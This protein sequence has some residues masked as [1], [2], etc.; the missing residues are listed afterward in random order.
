M[1]LLTL[2]VFFQGALISQSNQAVRLSAALSLHSQVSSLST[3]FASETI[4]KDNSIRRICEHGGKRLKTHEIEFIP[5][6]YGMF[7]FARLCPVKTVQEEQELL[8]NIKSMGVSVSSGTSYHFEEP[9]WFRLCY[10]V[11]LDQL[12]Q[13]LRRIY[14]GM[15]NYGIQ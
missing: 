5:A 9:G 15:V 7:V 14:L 4:L 11:P 3:V 1:H 12:E 13:A 6:A 10:G 2:D 8:G